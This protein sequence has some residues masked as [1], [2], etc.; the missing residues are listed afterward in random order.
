MRRRFSLICAV[1]L[2]LA[3]PI[4][5][6]ADATPQWLGDIPGL[7]E[8]A[9]D[10]QPA[11]VPVNLGGCTITNPLFEDDPA[12]VRPFVPARYELGTNAFFGPQAAT[13]IAAVLSC[14]SVSVDRRRPAP[15]VL[16]L[17]AVQVEQDPAGDNPAD[18]AWNLYTRSTLNVL[19][20]SSWYLI[21]AQ[22]DNAGFAARLRRMHLPVDL[23]AGLAYRADYDGPEKKDSVVIPTHGG[24]YRLTTTTRL[25]DPFVHNHDWQFWHD[26]PRGESAGLYLHLHAMSDSSCG[27]WISPAV[28]ATQPP[29]GATI[30]APPNSRIAKVLGARVRQTPYAF[31]H[32]PS[33]ARGYITL[34]SEGRG[35]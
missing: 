23:V 21:A 32:P 34:K 2:M 29:C 10:P 35:R 1:M 6:R 13:I 19:P 3:V 4:V 5:P 11:A 30:T 31:N 28:A 26:G 24:P 22:T 27:Y 17:V 12:R 16:A 9:P 33:Q 8:V 18:R 20:S 15:M 14:K 25:A 7:G